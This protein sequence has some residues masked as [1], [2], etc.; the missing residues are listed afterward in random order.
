[1][2]TRI[3]LTER[4]DTRSHHPHRQYQDNSNTKRTNKDNLKRCQNTDIFITGYKKLAGFQNP[5][6][7]KKDRQRRPIIGSVFDF[8]KCT[9]P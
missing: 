2:K 3:F 5:A 8:R 6:V 1:M 7:G 9:Q 4:C